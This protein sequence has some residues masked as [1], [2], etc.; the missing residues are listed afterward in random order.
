MTRPDR[1][2]PICGASLADRGADA[3]VRGDS[4]RR[5]RNRLRQLLAG[6][7]DSRY[8]TPFALDRDAELEHY[9]P[10]GERVAA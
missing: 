8:G 1:T 4:C 6:K 7:P 2:C 5:E 3:E 10:A 9:V